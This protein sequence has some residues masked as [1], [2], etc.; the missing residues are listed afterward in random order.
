MYRLW[1]L[2]FI[3]FSIQA[4]AE[5][6]DVFERFAVKMLLQELYLR[7]FLL[8]SEQGEHYDLSPEQLQ[9]TWR[10][11]YHVLKNFD[12][13]FTHPAVEIEDILKQAR[14]FQ[15]NQ[16]NLTK[17]QSQSAE[18]GL[19]DFLAHHPVKLAD[20]RSMI[21]P[22][23]FAKPEL[24]C[25]LPSAI[26]KALHLPTADFTSSSVWYQPPLQLK[27]QD[28]DCISLAFIKRYLQ[29]PSVSHEPKA[30][31]EAMLVLRNEP[32]LRLLLS[33][34]ALYHQE[35]R[36][37]LDYLFPL[38]HHSPVYRYAYEAVQ[39]VYQFAEKG[40]GAVALKRL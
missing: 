34:R 26:Q 32:K 27:A 9:N 13:G 31:L 10:G 2:I 25:K 6:I 5:E 29:Q 36:T 33:W 21:M 18:Q 7:E 28:L 17:N 23:L 30:W 24:N 14:L 40:K 16:Q 15:M 12:E 4:V 8:V 37:S 3:I 1:T 39:R 11:A 20:V 22:I 38:V 19:S 35:Y